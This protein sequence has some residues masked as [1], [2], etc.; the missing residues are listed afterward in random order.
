MRVVS[1]KILSLPLCPKVIRCAQALLSMIKSIDYNVNAW[2]AQLS[3]LVKI[4]HSKKLSLNLE[5]ATM[6]TS[7]FGLL[8]LLASILV[9]FLIYTYC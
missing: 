4:D 3:L 6:L 7:L 2:N 1:V 9:S 8:Y 5:K